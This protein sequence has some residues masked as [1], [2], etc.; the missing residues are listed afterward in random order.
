M[1]LVWL[2]AASRSARLQRDQRL[3]PDALR[4]LQWKRLR[5]ILRHAY[6]RSP[7]YREKLDRSGV[8]PEEV[9]T[10]ED[11]ARIPLLRR[12]DLRAPE[13]ILARDFSLDRLPS[14]F[15]SGSTAVG[16]RTYFDPDAWLLGRY[17]IKLRARLACGVRPWDRIALFQWIPAAETPLRRHLLRQRSFG[18]DR[19][20]DD[21]L[22]EV[23][24]YAPTVLYGFPGYLRRLGEAAKG[25]I[26]P[27]LV[28]T[29]GEILDRETRRSIEEAFGAATYDIYG[30][31][32][33]KEIAWECPERGSYHINADWLYVEILPEAAEDAPARSIVVTSL[34]NYAMP[35]IRYLVG[36]AGRL[37]DGVCGCGRT[38]PLMAPEIG[39]AVDYVR[40]PGGGEVSPYTVMTPV[41]ALP[42][43]GQFEVLQESIDRVVVRI[44][45]SPS[46]GEGTRREILES[47]NSILPGIRVDVEIVDRIEPQR[48]GKYRIVQTRIGDRDGRDGAAPR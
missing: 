36:D 24:R 44:V 15:S 32:E 34:Y 4:A 9:R 48:S 30:C 37:I 43:V 39:R 2:R 28:F 38:L 41:E 35:L 11:L 47:L 17:L 14:S 20:F 40:L 3:P 19:S 31:T 33:M 26:R 8:R 6:D 25:R 45:P 13:K 5:R 10:P 7:H 27:R 42:G 16:T 12:E 1:S 22:P 46:Y 18:I 23:R 21:V 29:S